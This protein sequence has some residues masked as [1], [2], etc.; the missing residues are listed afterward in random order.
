MAK[1]IECDICH[2]KA[3]IYT[4]K[5][6]TPQYFDSYCRCTNEQCGTTF[7]METTFSRRITPS[8]LD[9]NTFIE[10][11]IAGMD[12]KKRTELLERYQTT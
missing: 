11:L 9:M 12:E 3:I 2:S 5:S 8:K 4:T 6:I 7:V 1:K 10:S